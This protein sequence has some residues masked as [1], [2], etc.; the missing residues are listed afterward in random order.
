MSFSWSKKQIR[1]TSAISDTGFWKINGNS[2]E[3]EHFYDTSLSNAV[4]NFL[5]KN[6]IRR[7]YDFGCGNGEYVNNFRKQNIIS[8]GFDGNPITNSIPNCSVL[9]LT[10]NFSLEPVEFVMC[11]EVG[12][13]IPSKY[14]DV[15]IKNVTEQVLPGG[16][17]LMSWALPGQPG[18]G[19]INCRPTKYII[20]KISDKGFIYDNDLTIHFRN[21]S[22]IWWFKNTIMFF[23][24]K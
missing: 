20:S 2:F 5:L 19:H 8:E 6:N 3:K 4:M 21:M 14:E 15:L 10:S 16:Y 17:L 9:D 24:K 13:H 7:V 12:E 23:Q 22:S 18:L 1:S 11:L